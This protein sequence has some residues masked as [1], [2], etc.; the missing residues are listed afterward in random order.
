M[1]TL[2]V[3]ATA[4]GAL[5]CKIVL[6]GSWPKNSILKLLSAQKRLAALPDVPT[7]KELGFAEFS[8][9]LWYAFLA[10][11]STPANTMLGLR[12]AFAS[13]VMDPSVQERLKTLGFAPE[14]KDSATVSLLMKNVA[15]RSG[16]V[17]KDN[18][19]TST[20]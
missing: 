14:I 5:Q 3:R 17:I 9:I 1:D 12:D 4:A 8:P 7:M 18:K 10:P 6:E 16:R 2:H 20:D 11:A 15:I 19:I 13:A